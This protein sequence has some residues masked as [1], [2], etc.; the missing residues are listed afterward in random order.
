MNHVYQDRDV[1][2]V[3]GDAR[4]R[5]VVVDLEMWVEDV[6]GK[7]QITE[8]KV[9]MYKGTVKKWQVLDDLEHDREEI[10]KMQKAVSAPEPEELEMYEEQGKIPMQ[11]PFNNYNATQWRDERKANESADFDPE[12]IK[13][14]REKRKRFFIER[15]EKPRELTE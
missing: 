11:L 6:I 5:Q 1:V 4:F 8:K 14:D 12:H 9:N 13:L 3:E 10:V 15:F 2:G 7:K